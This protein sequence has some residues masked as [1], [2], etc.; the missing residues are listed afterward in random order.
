MDTAR[1]AT[2]LGSRERRT[3]IN[4]ELLTMVEHEVL[5]WPGVCKKLGSDDLQQRTDPITATLDA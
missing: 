5:G 2:L 4:D 1:R 3:G